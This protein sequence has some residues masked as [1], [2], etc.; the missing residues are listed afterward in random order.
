[1]ISPT[2]LPLSNF[3]SSP[4]SEARLPQEPIQETIIVTLFGRPGYGALPLRGEGVELAQPEELES[5]RKASDVTIGQGVI[6][7]RAQTQQRAT[8]LA[9]KENHRSSAG[10]KYFPDSEF[11]N[12]C[13]C[14]S[15]IQNICQHSRQQLHLHFCIDVEISFKCAFHRFPTY[16]SQ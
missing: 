9:E 6:L 7:L 4:I 16:E 11:Q 12:G 10:D 3:S 14:K 8:L 2:P 15:S 13:P 1:M 5:Q